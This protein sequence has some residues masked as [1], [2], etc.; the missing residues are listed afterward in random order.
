MNERQRRNGISCRGMETGEAVTLLPEG[1]R[2]V[3]DGDDGR[4]A[5]AAPPE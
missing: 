1:D 3:G 5:R 2:G 4:Q